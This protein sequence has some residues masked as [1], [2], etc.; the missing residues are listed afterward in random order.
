METF[1]TVIG[2]S[3]NK[4]TEKQGAYLD[5]QALERHPLETSASDNLFTVTSPPCRSVTGIR[6]SSPVLCNT[7]FSF[8]KNHNH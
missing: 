5:K 3:V 8:K 4:R 2:Q 1:K 7:S 6:L